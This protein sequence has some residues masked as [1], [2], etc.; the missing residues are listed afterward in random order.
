MTISRRCIGTMHEPHPSLGLKFQVNVRCDGTA[1]PGN[2]TAPSVPCNCNCHA[3]A[4]VP[5]PIKEET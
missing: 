1:Q 3:Q 4:L 2:L 5:I